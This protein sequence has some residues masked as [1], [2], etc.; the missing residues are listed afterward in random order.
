MPKRIEKRG[1]N[2]YRFNISAGIEADDKQI[3]HRK[4]LTVKDERQLECE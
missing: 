3:V 4:T 2:R 1:E